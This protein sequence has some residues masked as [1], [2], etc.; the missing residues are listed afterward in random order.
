LENRVE[1]LRRG[2]GISQA[3][4]GRQLKFHGNRSVRQENTIHLYSIVVFP[5]LGQLEIIDNTRIMLLY[6]GAYFIFQIIMGVVIF[7][8]PLWKYK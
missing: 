6:L 2:L 4:F 5:V 1:E 3:D 8:H 7:N